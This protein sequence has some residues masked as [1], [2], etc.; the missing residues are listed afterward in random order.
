MFHIDF[1]KI[2]AFTVRQEQKFLPTHAPRELK[3]LYIAITILN[4]ASAS[5]ILF[6][7]IYLY[8]NGYPIW[9]M[10]LFYLGVYGIYFFTMPLGAKV[11]VR[12]GY[13]HGIMY[14][15]VFMILYFV[16]LLNI[17]AHPIFI[18]LAVLASALQKTMFWPG[19][20]ADFAY[21]SQADERA[22]EIGIIAI[23][24]AV[25][26]VLG[27]LVGGI[28]VSQFGF[29]ALFAGMCV[30]ILL[31]NIPLLI[32]RERFS[33][34]S[35]SYAQPYK[36]IV[37]RK[38][39]RKTIGF[40]GFGE[41]LIV[42]LVWPVFI[43]VMIQ[44]YLSTGLIVATSTLITSL[45]ILIVGRMADGGRQPALYHAGVIFVGLAWAFRFLVRGAPSVVMVDFFSR[46]SKYV[47]ALPF[48]SMLYS[49]A[50]NA[51]SILRIVTHFEMSLVIGKISA[52]IAVFALFY[53]FG[54]IWWAAF[55][56]GGLYSLLYFSLD[57]YKKRD[58]VPPPP[59]AALLL[60]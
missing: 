4:F 14:G 35:F 41:E 37:D 32:I 31:S 21:F 25:S 52:L 39:L 15:S 44:D 18:V 45:V 58:Y 29:S 7:P 53:F 49:E 3:K 1:K 51:T 47:F 8:S 38:N 11:V 34:G 54:E 48:F 46:V 2:I 10:A 60:K 57:G 50:H 30:V 12:K 6:E 24:D 40:M 19:Y 27:P 55:L 9:W 36:D 20:H 59:D 43:Y 56:L 17:S 16:F 28:V 5:G 33:P 23:L 42:L 26:Y 13:E 22:R